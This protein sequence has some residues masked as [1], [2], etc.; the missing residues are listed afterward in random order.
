MKKN[1]G[2][3]WIFRPT[4]LP[5]SRKFRK[6]RKFKDNFCSLGAGDKS[7]A[8]LADFVFHS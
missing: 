3:K 8:M 7:P 6:F 1:K 2:K 4:F 5:L